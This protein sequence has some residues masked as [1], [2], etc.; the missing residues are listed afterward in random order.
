MF[1][2]SQ[3]DSRDHYTVTWSSDLNITA[4]GNGELGVELLKGSDPGNPYNVNGVQKLDQ[5]NM[6]GNDHVD[7]FIASMTKRLTEVLPGHCQE[8]LGGVQKS[9]KVRLLLHRDF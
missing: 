3:R 4:Q 9:R 6:C 8:H 7:N 1:S 2:Y 5:C